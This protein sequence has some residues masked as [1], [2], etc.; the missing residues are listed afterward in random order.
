MRAE[1]LID[2]VITSK[3]SGDCC[4]FAL[5]AREVL[6]RGVFL[7][8]GIHGALKMEIEE[9]EKKSDKKKEKKKKKKREI[10]EEKQKKKKKGGDGRSSKENKKE[11]KA[12]ASKTTIILDS[13]AREG[14]A[15][16]TEE[17]K[18]FEKFSW[19]LIDKQVI[20]INVR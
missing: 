19:I 20:I 1:L 4:Y 17:I 11:Q 12:K 14:F 13:S 15:L 6:D 9:K 8:N 18:T 7:H 2:V 5:S 16:K 3:S 10:E